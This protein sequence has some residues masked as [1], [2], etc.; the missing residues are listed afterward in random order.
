MEWISG[1]D[2]NILE[3]LYFF[4]QICL[5]GISSVVI[6][7]T[8]GYAVFQYNNQKKHLKI[9]K[10]AELAKLY[11][12]TIIED[13]SDI[14]SVFNTYEINKIISEKIDLR[15]I[16]EFNL[17]ELKKLLPEEDIKKIIAVSMIVDFV[18]N[19]KNEKTIR[20]KKQNGE[21][22]VEVVHNETSLKDS[23][24]QLLNKLEYFCMHFNS[25]VAE[26]KTVY[27]SLHQSFFITV[28]NLYVFIARANDDESSCD[29]YYTN[30][31]KVYKKWRKIKDKQERKEAKISRKIK[32]LEE[33]KN[34]NR[35][36]ILYQ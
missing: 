3:K 21:E 12:E 4:T 23:I 14:L 18:Y 24:T 27:Q 7:A 26:D 25:G 33:K 19:G 9:I 1:M 10:A 36:K 29:K 20:F 6:P 35:D 2:A 8:L 16:S 28:E 17:L 30:I 22:P 31:I 32:R 11:Q 13:I 15:K 5:A 34:V